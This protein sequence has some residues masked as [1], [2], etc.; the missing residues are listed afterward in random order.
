[1]L[2]KLLLVQSFE[3]D[4]IAVDGIYMTVTVYSYN[5]ALGFE[6]N[7]ITCWRCYCSLLSMLKVHLLY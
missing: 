3:N 7:Y 5:D 2:V 1:M 4:K 6:C